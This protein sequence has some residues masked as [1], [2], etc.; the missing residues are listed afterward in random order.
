MRIESSNIERSDIFSDEIERS[1][2]ELLEAIL[3]SEQIEFRELEELL[4]SNPKFRAWYARR[5][6][7]RQECQPL[8]RWQMGAVLH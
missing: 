1:D 2:Y 4:R 7:S 8:E 3:L 6:K 5:A